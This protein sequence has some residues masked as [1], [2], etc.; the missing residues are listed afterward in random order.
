MG[1]IHAVLEDEVDYGFEGGGEYNTDIAD[2]ENRF[3]DR[4]SAW[5]FPKHKYS[6]NFSNLDEADRDRFIEIFHACRG[7]RHSF[8]IKDWNDFEGVDQPL[9]VAVSTTNKVQLYKTYTFGPAYTIRPIFAFKTV[10]ILDETDTPVPGTMNL[11]TGEFT[12]DNPW[13]VG[14]YKWT[15]EFYVWVRFDSDYNTLTINAWRNHT[16]NIELIEDPIKITA[17]NV[18]MSWEE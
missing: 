9:A 16:A 4:D 12:P 6:A 13:G 2:L 17:T 3:E 11:W 15:G 18:P 10:Q 1:R 7:R 8:L 14:P 5:K